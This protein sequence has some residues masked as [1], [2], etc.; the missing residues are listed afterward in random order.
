MYYILFYAHCNVDKRPS[1]FFAFEDD[2]NLT[3]DDDDDDEF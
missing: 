1:I 3:D 2:D